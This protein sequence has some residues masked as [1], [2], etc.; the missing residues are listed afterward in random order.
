MEISHNTHVIVQQVFLIGSSLKAT[1]SHVREE[2]PGKDVLVQLVTKELFTKKANLAQM[3]LL[4]KC[5]CWL[6]NYG[7]CNPIGTTK[8]QLS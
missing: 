6:A 5:C 7:S 1:S 4:T 8:F 3:F 2:E